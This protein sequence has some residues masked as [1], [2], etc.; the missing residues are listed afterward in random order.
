MNASETLLKPTTVESKK[1]HDIGELVRQAST[2]IGPVWP[3]KNGIACN[4]LLGLE[5][6]EFWESIEETESLFSHFKPFTSLNEAKVN[7]HFIKWIQAFLDQGQA[8]WKMPDRHLGFYR[9]WHLL[10]PYDRLLIRTN[11][12]RKILASFPEDPENAIELGMKQLGVENNN[13]VEYLAG[14]LAQLPGWAGYVK[15]HTD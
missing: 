14:Q 13:E 7:R 9:C 3:L 11:T 8:T 6:K 4:P 10:A 2:L 12:H 15:W 5:H 1:T